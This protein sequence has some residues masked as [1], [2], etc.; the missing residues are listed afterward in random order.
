MFRRGSSSFRDGNH[1]HRAYKYAALDHQ[2][3]AATC[4]I[5]QLSIRHRLLIIA[6]AALLAVAFA[7]LSGTKCASPVYVL[8]AQ[9]IISSTALAAPWKYGGPGYGLPSTC[10]GDINAG[11]Q[12][13]PEISHFWGQYSPF[14]SVPSEISS[15]IPSQCKITFA[16]VLSRHGARDPTASKTKQ[17]AALISKLHSNVKNYTGAYTFLQTFNYSLGADLLTTFGQQELVD[18]GRKFYNRYESLTSSA[19]IFVRSSGQERVVESAMNFTQGYHAANCEHSRSACSND[20]Y[21]YPILAIPEENGV[22]NTLNHALCT[23]F[24]NGTD[25]NIGSNA[26]AIWNKIWLPPI[27]ARLNRDLAGA[28]LTQTETQ[29]FMDLCPFETVVNGTYY[30]PICDLFT[31]DEW[32]QYDYFQALGKYYGYGNG[33]PLGP[34]QGVG[35]T[36]ELI[37]R[38]TGKPVDDETSTNHTL[39]DN[40]ATFPVGKGHSIFADFSHD[41]D[42]TAIFAA[43]GLYNATQPLSNT[44]I[45]TTQQTNGYSA[46]WTVPFAARAYFE[47]MQCD[48]Q[49]EELV[50]ILVNDRVIPLVKCGA[51]SLGRCTLSKWVNSLSFARGDGDWAACFT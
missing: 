20:G 45:E 18:S 31:A 44:S 17:Y 48:G 37:A 39:D 30:S 42:M 25:S 26:Q 4:S 29:L 3:G 49:S 16:Q 28:N 35:F 46:S 2:H 22:N 43:M 47:K 15:D 24:E 27:T 32:H 8:V 50:R 19:S 38:M 40:P 10:Y 11:Y 41:N 33:N 1:Q 21:P 14:F 23:A 9:L 5:Y 13:K 12:C 7:L 34:T 36:N 51:D 6:M